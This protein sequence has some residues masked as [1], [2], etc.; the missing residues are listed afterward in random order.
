MNPGALPRHFGD[1]FQDIETDIRKI[2]SRLPEGFPQSLVPLTENVNWLKNE[3]TR[4]VSHSNHEFKRLSEALDLMRK[5]FAE[6]VATC[7]PS[8]GDTKP[9]KRGKAIKGETTLQVCLQQ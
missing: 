7:K 9:H 4:Y 8:Q 1:K 6:H 3:F 5:D 2:Q